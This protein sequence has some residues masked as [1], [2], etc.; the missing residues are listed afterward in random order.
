VHG[1][2]RGRVTTITGAGQTLLRCHGKVRQ[3]MNMFKQ[4]RQAKRQKTGSI[5]EKYDVVKSNSQRRVKKRNAW[6]SSKVTRGPIWR[7]EQKRGN[8]KGARACVAARR[9]NGE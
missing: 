9:G 3:T 4:A 7:K 5:A 1:V 6:G 8:I 2:S